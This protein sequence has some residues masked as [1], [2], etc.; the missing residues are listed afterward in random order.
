MVGYKPLLWFVK[1]KYEG[2]FV[3][4]VKRSEFQGKELHDWA[5]STVESDYYIKYMTLENDI[6]Y[7]PFM[8][9]GTFG[10]SAVKLKRQFIG[11]ENDK[12][13]FENARRLLSNVNKS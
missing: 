1:G 3:S 11:V 5:Q 8:G 12:G 10:I 7:D 2:E 9:Q 4:D 13:H 6:V